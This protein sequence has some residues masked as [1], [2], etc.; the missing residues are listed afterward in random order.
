MIVSGH[1]LIMCNCGRDIHAPVVPYYAQP[2]TA[3]ACGACAPKVYVPP[4]A[5]VWP[6][7]GAPGC[8]TQP[9]SVGTQAYLLQPAQS[10]QQFAYQQVQLPIAGVGTAQSAAL[11]GGQ[12]VVLTSQQITL[13]ANGQAI[14]LSSGQVITG[15]VVNGQL[16]LSNGQVISLQQAGVSA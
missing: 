8:L 13:L 16:V 14:R 6:Y 10:A 9:A 5:K 1:P 7:N 11:Y 15:Q 3:V 12:P 4:C 2:V